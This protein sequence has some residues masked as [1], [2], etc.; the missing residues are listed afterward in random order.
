MGIYNITTAEQSMKTPLRILQI[1]CMPV[2]YPTDERISLPDNLYDIEKFLAKFCFCVIKG[3]LNI[4]KIMIYW[5]MLEDSK[6]KI[7]QYL[8]RMKHINSLWPNDSIWWQRSESTL[9]QVW[10]HQA[11]IWTNVEFS[12]ARPSD[13]HLRASSQEIPQPSI[14]EIICNIK[15]LKFHSNFPGANELNHGPWA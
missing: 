12:S 11:I 2:S 10:R 7:F 9:A 8:G 13:I 14:I 5:V 6:G 1:H 3:S 4:C 15:Y